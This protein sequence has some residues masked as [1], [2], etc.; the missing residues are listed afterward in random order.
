MTKEM[1]RMSKDNNKIT[2]KP[3]IICIYQK[4]GYNEKYKY[5]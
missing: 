3:L 2:K 1:S 5:K 4:S